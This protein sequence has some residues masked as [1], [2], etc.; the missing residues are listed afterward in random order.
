MAQPDDDARRDAARIAVGA[1]ELDRM[2]E[3]MKSSVDDSL[4]GGRVS[5]PPTLGIMTRADPDA[6]PEVTVA[7][8]AVPFNSDAE[9]REAL[10]AVGR[11]LFA[12]KSVPVAA[13][14]ACEAWL[15][16]MRPGD[17]RR[18]ADHPDREEVILCQGCTLGHKHAAFA[19]L[20]LTRG[21][22]NRII[23]GA[24]R[25]TVTE[26]CEARLVLQLWD[27]FFE[28]VARK[29]GYFERN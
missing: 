28:H 3:A 24:W 5:I 26:H 21:D 29:F 14:L 8:L 1:A 6:A 27:G 15:A 16:S 20:P 9:K 10:R 11:R 7:V 12:E 4:R 18:P 13:V 25:P 22:G 19:T 23:P 17:R 2:V